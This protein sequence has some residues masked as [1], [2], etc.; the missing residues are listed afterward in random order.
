MDVTLNLFYIIG[1]VGYSLLM[2]GL[3]LTALAANQRQ[4]QDHGVNARH[5]HTEVAYFADRFATQRRESHRLKDALARAEG[6]LS[7]SHAHV[8]S[9]LDELD[10][11][12]AANLSTV[13][14]YTALSNEYAW[15]R[16]LVASKDAHL[17]QY[18]LTTSK[19]ATHPLE[20]SDAG[21][22]TPAYTPS[23]DHLDKAC[24]AVT[25]SKTH[26]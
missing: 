21:V 23:L 11:L 12:K 10:R 24:A 25:R 16:S 4:A 7:T 15:F 2:S 14:A 6:N 8:S 13:K 26:A 18:A 3:Y 17:Y 5:L 1:L 9:Y 20:S 19:T 22:S